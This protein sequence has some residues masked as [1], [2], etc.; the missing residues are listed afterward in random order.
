MI[1]LKLLMNTI[2]IGVTSHPLYYKGK[3]ATNPRS[4]FQRHGNYLFLLIFKM[5]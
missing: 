1:S 2:K 3:K 4:E 5:N